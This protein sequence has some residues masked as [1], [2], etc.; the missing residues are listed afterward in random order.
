MKKFLFPILFL[1]LLSFS[2]S[3]KED[4]FLTDNFYR[5]QVQKD[6][7]TKAEALDGKLDIN[8]LFDLYTDLKEKEALEW[9]YAYMPISDIADY[10]VEFFAEG[11]KSA[12]TAREQMPWGKDVP[13]D[14]FR[15]FVLPIR[16]NN[17]NLDNS[18]E[19]F[20]DELKGRVMGLSMYDAALEVNHWCH[21]KVIYTPSDGRT[22]S[23]LASVKTAYGRCGEESVLAVAALRSVGIP[24]RQVY[25]PRWAH[26]DDNHAWV[27]VWVDGKWYYLGAC[28]PQAKLNVAWF[29]A[30]AQRAILMHSKVF[31]KYKTKEDIIQQTDCYTEINVTSNYAP[32]SKVEVKI[33]DENGATVP[34]VKVEFKIYNYAEL[35]SAITTTTSKNGRAS[36]TFGNGDIIVW[37]SKGSKLGFKKVSVG[38]TPNPVIIPLDKQTGETIFQEIDIVPPA[39]RKA[40]IILTKEEIA[41][42]AFR[43]AA[44]DS[45]R[46]LYTDTFASE[47]DAATL[48]HH[49]Y[50]KVIYDYLTAARGNWKEISHFI[51]SLSDETF[52]RGMALLSLI[53]AKD[54]RDTPAEILEDHLNNYQAPLFSPELSL[55]D[56]IAI[57]YILNPRI[58]N[59]LLSPWRSTFR[60]MIKEGAVGNSEPSPLNIIEFVKKVKILG[61]YNPQNI[62]MSPEGVLSLM[63][64]DLHSRDIF[65]IALCRSAGI[66]AR[67]EEVSGKVQYFNSGIWYDVNF[68]EERTDNEAETTP[69][70]SIILSYSGES[71]IDDPKFDTHFTI[72]KIENGSINTLNFRDKEGYEGTAS[73]RGISQ[74]PI[75]LDEGWYML[76]TG[77]RMAS[78]KVLATISLFNVI[79]DQSCA[80]KLIMRE[81]KNDLQVIGNM[82][83]ESRF[84]LLFPDDTSIPKS[85]I[86]TTG[87]GFFFLVF[88][89]AN[90]EPSTHTMKSLFQKEPNR[91]TIIFF[92]D[93]RDYIS[94]KK[95]ENRHIPSG[96]SF[97]IDNDDELLSPILKEMKIKTPEYPIVIIADTFGRIVYLSQGYNIGT[98]EQLER[99]AK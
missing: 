10:S 6:L 32:T 53:S 1:L 73:Y 99:I 86:E 68:D 91:P 58:S 70:G 97:G 88:A 54:L 60:K 20:F 23:P 46:G 62:P 92:K 4:H 47:G 59:E 41:S 22:S 87:R 64:S 26:T 42:N 57:K 78:G 5:R 19:I 35:Y 2:C 36:A 85:I 40:E 30:T 3:K 84:S 44:E 8:T 61:Q 55:S 96:I 72:A 31:G 29:S 18:R 50:K 28:E 82:N 65:F 12:F 74:R 9:L 56:T 25:T 76:T 90:H 13:E 77:T 51:S 33:I 75:K 89:K 16:V 79:M 15:H 43:L 24:S 81:D 48:G 21:E 14:I 66:P 37:A 52:D 7:T 49:P 71:F 38:A 69:T 11:V 95:S 17:E 34:D 80:V 63:A 45:I 39:E 67:F 93:K 94:F 83:P 27:E 98:V